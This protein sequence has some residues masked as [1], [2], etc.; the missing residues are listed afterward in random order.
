[1]YRE[2]ILDLYRKPRNEGSLETEY[3]AEGENRSCGDHTEVF[4]ELEDGSVSR[5]RH[6]TDGCAICTAATSIVSEELEGMK[7]TKVRDLDKDWIIDELGIDISPMRTKCAVLGLK[8]FQKALEK[9][10]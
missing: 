1:M 6:Q 3:R 10:E 5:A 7:T 4:L 8:T 2:E 9:D